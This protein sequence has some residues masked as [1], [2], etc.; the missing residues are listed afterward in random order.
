MIG[1][2]TAARHSG[3]RARRCSA[4][5]GAFISFPIFVMTFEFNTYGQRTLS[6]ETD[7]YTPGGGLVVDV[8]DEAGGPY[9]RVSVNCGASLA[10]DEFVFRTCAENDG[11]LKAMLAARVIEPTGRFVGVGFEGLKPVCRL[12]APVSQH[13]P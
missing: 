10:D 6:V 3:R 8:I 4:P 11:L 2:I 9:A 13:R 1:C 12:L 7:L 5:F